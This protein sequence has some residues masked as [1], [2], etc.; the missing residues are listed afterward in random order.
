MRKLIAGIVLA[1]TMLG[2]ASPPAMAQYFPGWGPPPPPRGYYED[3]RY[4]APPGYYGYPA[5]ESYYHGRPRQTLR[6]ICVT[7]RGNCPTG[8]P[9]PA[10][11]RAA[12]TFPASATSA[13]P[14]PSAERPGRDAFAPAH[15]AARGGP[16]RSPL[17][18]APEFIA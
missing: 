17:P 16:A 5:R 1:L 4:R 6:A 8:Q 11:R 13:A 7:S 10:A 2:A 9:F 18:H 12:A 3:R 14:F 15:P